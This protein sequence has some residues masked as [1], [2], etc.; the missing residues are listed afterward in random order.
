MRTTR[1]T[2][3]LV[4][5]SIVALA[6]LPF[7]GINQFWIFFVTVT[8]TQTIVLA[9]LNITLGYAGLISL[10]HNAL[11]AIGG[12]ATAYFSVS[13]GVPVGVA[14]LLGA[15]FGCGAGVALA[16]TTFRTRAVYFGIITLAFLFLT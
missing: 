16:L 13:R 9:S 15:A 2:K 12:Y 10:G 8:I 5:A 11:Y 14:I 1:L 6:S 3:G 7:W 4:V